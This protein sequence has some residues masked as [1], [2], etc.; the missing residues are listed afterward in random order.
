MTETCSGCKTT[1]II[2]Q[3]ETRNDHTQQQELLCASCV[4]N[5]QAVLDCLRENAEQRK[6]EKEQAVMRARQLW[7]QDP[8]LL[9]IDVGG[10]LLKKHLQK[11]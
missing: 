7:E 1:Q 9:L 8:V 3:I 6:R 4:K 5:I 10:H 11:Y 2:V